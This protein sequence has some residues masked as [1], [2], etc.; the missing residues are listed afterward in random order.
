MKSFKW[1][2]MPLALAILLQPLTAVSADSVAVD[3]ARA[4]APWFANMYFAIEDTGTYLGKVCQHVWK[5]CQETYN[6]TCARPGI[7]VPAISLAAAGLVWYNL[8]TT[9]R[10]RVASQD[11]IQETKQIVTTTT[12]QG[13]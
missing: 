9:V 3:S 6:F 12:T 1:I 13:R 4:V 5:I 10:T 2:V 7:A 8:P 11:K